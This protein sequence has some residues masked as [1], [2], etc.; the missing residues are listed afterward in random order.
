MQATFSRIIFKRLR[1]FLANRSQKIY[2]DDI[3][4]AP[5]YPMAYSVLDV[6][7]LETSLQILSTHSSVS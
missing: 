2:S 5:P 3:P 7:F 6:L 4:R 1:V